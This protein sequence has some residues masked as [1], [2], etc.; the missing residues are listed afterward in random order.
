MKRHSSLGDCFTVKKI[1]I[2]TKCRVDV[3]RA[4]GIKR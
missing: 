2:K 1:E 4:V 3:F